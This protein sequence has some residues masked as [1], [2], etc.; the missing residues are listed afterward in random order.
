MNVYVFI[1][2]ND[3]ERAERNR[4]TSVKNIPLRAVSGPG[5][6]QLKNGRWRMCSTQ[7]MGRSCS[8]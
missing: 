1:T 5:T 4:Q 8:V 3:I 7:C 6:Y 2:S